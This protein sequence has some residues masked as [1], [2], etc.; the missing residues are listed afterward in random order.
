[1]LLN[2][3]LC[4]RFAEVLLDP[5]LLAEDTTA[6]VASLCGDPVAPPGES[7]PLS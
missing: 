4:R 1:M 3:P 6:S 7:S 2:E 5:L